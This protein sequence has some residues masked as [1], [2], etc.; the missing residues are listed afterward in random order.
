MSTVS[1]GWFC[2]LT[3]RLF[4]QWTGCKL[5]RR[6]TTRLASNASTMLANTLSAILQWFITHSPTHPSTHSSHLLTHSTY[7]PTHSL[8]H[9]LT[10]THPLHHL[11]THSYTHLPYSFILFP[12][13]TPHKMQVPQPH[14][15][16]FYLITLTASLITS[17]T[18]CPLTCVCAC[19]QFSVMIVCLFHNTL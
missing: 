17:L 5:T 7:S 12:G 15:N 10:H 6:Y 8:T 1:D 9:L 11:S 2:Y 18:H 19:V 13:I 14:V 3:R 4:T 16:L